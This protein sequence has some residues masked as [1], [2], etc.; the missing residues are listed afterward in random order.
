M[1]VVATVLCVSFLITVA[2]LRVNIK[3]EYVNK[4]TMYISTIKSVVSAEDKGRI[5]DYNAFANFIGDQWEEY[6]ITFI[7]RDGQVLGDSEGDITLMDNHLKRAEVSGALRGHISSDIRRSATTG[8][9]LVYVADR[10]SEDVIIRVS[11]PIKSMYKTF[12]EFLP[13]IIIGLFVAMG[14]SIPVAK[15][16]SLSLAQPIIRIA[17]TLKRVQSDSDFEV[18]SLGEIE[19][20]QPIIGIVTKQAESLRQSI[21]LLKNEQRKTK[22]ILD[23]M[24]QGLIVA[25]EKGRILII[26][27]WASK[28]FGAAGDA[29]G[30]NINVICRDIDFLR[31]FEQM[32]VNGENSTI[33]IVADRFNETTIRCH[34]SKVSDRLVFG[35]E[36]IVGGVV[37]VTDVSEKIKL[38]RFRRDFVANVSHELK[39]PITSI[40]GFSELISTN[41][42]TDSEKIVK[43]AGYIYKDANRLAG[44]VEDILRLEEAQNTVD[45]RSFTNINLKNIILSEVDNL[46]YKAKLKDVTINTKLSD[47]YFDCDAK[48]MTALFANLITNAINYNKQG[49]TV[50]VDL[51]QTDD[52]IE[53]RVS[54]TGIGIPDKERE[55]I[56]ERFYRVDKGRS[57]EQGGTGLGLAIVKYTVLQYNGRIEVHSEINKGSTFTVILPCR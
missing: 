53:L 28:V 45:R 17:N 9:E 54:D 39:T 48:D 56:F 11:S 40:Q 57:R 8:E 5:S 6:R 7:G 16:M 42:V 21:N 50:N 26:N 27:E 25:D 38:E 31:S 24:E 14:I 44:L 12:T 15:R 35:D 3:D 10:F 34:F 43:F 37:L 36:S 41:T 29:Y 49:G 23:S 20:I 22:Y 51:K 32:I 1:I 55:R 30:K 33:D 18:K 2:I 13:A 47:V 19:E 46:Q 4:L 52:Q